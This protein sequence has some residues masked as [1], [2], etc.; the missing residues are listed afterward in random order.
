MAR[1]DNGPSARKRREERYF[2]KL[3]KKK[4]PPVSNLAILFREEKDDNDDSVLKQ[5]TRVSSPATSFREVNKLVEL[6]DS[7][8]EVSNMT[9]YSDEPIQE[10]ST[11]WNADDFQSL[12]PN[13]KSAYIKRYKND[14]QNSRRRNMSFE[15]EEWDFALLPRT[16]NELAKTAEEDILFPGLIAETKQKVLLIIYEFAQKK[17]MKLIFRKGQ[18][19]KHRVCLYG[20]KDGKI[21]EVS[22]GRRKSGWKVVKIASR[23]PTIGKYVAV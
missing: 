7:D 13:G 16:R 12:S 21:V 10:E 17:S 3:Q 5:T 1:K 14:K 20:I 6:L 2:K 9:A 11:S 15:E 8:I 4:T 19:T 23:E 22:A 18:N